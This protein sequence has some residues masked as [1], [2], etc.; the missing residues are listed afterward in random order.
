MAKALLITSAF[1]DPV[2]P[3]LGAA[4]LK[5]Y[6]EMNGHQIDIVDLNTHEEIFAAQS[7]YFD[8][9]QR[10]F[11]YMKKWNIERNGTEM[12]SL[13]Q[14]VYLFARHKKN[15]KEMVA[16]VLNMDMRPLDD[17]MDKFNLERFDKLF[18]KLYQNIKQEIK[19]YIKK[20]IDVV[21]CHL[22]NSTWAS[23]LFILKYIKEKYPHIRTSVGGPG[24]IMGF[25]SDKKEIELFMK[26][27]NFI[28]Y[29]IVG[30]GEN[31]FLEI[32]NNKNLS[33]SIIDKNSLIN[34]KSLSSNKLKMHDLP[35][36]NFDGF[37]IDRYLMLSLSSSRGCPFECSFCAETVFWDGFR[38]NN[39][40]N[41]LE[42]MD[43][44]A[45][46]YQRSS[47]YICDSLS[48]HIVGPLTKLIAENNKGY[49]LDCYLRADRICTDEKRTEQWKQ[50]GLFRARLGMESASQRI[51][52]DMVKKTTPDNMSKSLKA[53]SKQG[54]L[55]TTL[56]IVGYPGE[57]DQEFNSTI[58]FI[59]ENRDYIFQSD[60]WVFQYHPSGLSGS[61]ELKKKGQK[62]RYSDEMN[63]ML[64]LTP[65]ALDD[66]I[67]P[68][69]K[70]ER[71]E[72]FTAKMDELKIPNPYTIPKMH[73]ALQ[74]FSNLHKE[75]SW[76]PLKSMRKLDT[77]LIK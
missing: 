39:A 35:A 38:P 58:S 24:P 12:L 70:F 69:E 46:K 18:D 64:A 77:K 3:P 76:D 41:V 61:K 59:E 29:F 67:E 56:W 22:N 65:Y 71:L 63:S 44:L 34:N 45:N 73:S 14:I 40:K 52:D 15:Y 62:L 6:G 20:E 1:W 75:P 4:S 49:L 72:R 19:K 13:H 5:S 55:T 23:T 25:I 28:D 32:L 8:E 11:P 51:L 36:P 17:F 21:G 2:C 10:Q 54:I 60:P 31:S 7:E 47:F 26:K 27:N 42:Q 53:L 66:D 68:A 43:L 74:R 37:D 48:N 9:I 30:E 16:D 50:G 57:T 33:P